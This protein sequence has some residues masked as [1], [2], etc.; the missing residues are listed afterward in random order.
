MTELIKRKGERNK[1]DYYPTPDYLAR[2]LVE[3]CLRAAAPSNPNGNLYVFEPGC[4]ITAPFV[5]AAAG[6]WDT[7]RLVVHW[8]DIQLDDVD[9]TQADA[10][11]GEK[12]D[13]VI[14]NPPFNQGLEFW[15]KAMEFTHPLGEVAFIVKTSFLQTVKRS[16][17]WRRHNP[18]R[19]YFLYPRPSFSGNGK[20]DIAQEYCAIRWRKNM[21]T[22]P[23]IVNWV[24]VREL[25]EKYA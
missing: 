5:R 11:K 3:E 22:G 6:Y 4:G 9:F 25:K 1:Y 12:Y 18:S 10:T 8:S 16:E 19:I 13:L 24:D 21:T 2:W 17:Q 20:T 7:K 14:T 23:T 15:H